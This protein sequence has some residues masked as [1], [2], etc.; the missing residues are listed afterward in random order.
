MEWLRLILGSAFL[1]VGIVFFAIQLYGIF[2]LDYA[3][4]RMHAAAMGDTL[5]LAF[6]ML[7]LMIFSGLNFNTFKMIIVVVLLWNASPVS[8]HLLARLEVMTNSKLENHLKV[9]YK[10][11]DLEDEPEQGSGDDSTTDQKG[12]TK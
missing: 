6:S 1:L 7:G 4:N 8:S 10:L 11:K 5:G 12:Q 9:Y 2:R 3:L